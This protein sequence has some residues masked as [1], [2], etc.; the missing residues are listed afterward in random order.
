METLRNWLFKYK[1]IL[2]GVITLLSSIAGIS[3]NLIS[4]VNNSNDN[5]VIGAAMVVFLFSVIRE[6]LKALG[7][8]SKI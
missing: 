1:T 4:V 2:S 3:D 7:K 6:I 8:E 5:A